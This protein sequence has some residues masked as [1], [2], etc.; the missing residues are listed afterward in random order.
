MGRKKIGSE[1]KK[2]TF[3]LNM[4]VELFQKIECLEIK[5]KSRFFSWL[6]DEYFDKIREGGVQ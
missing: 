4:S 3:T 6:L 2:K 1:N 5:N